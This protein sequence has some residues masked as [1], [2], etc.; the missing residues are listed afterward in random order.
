VQDVSQSKEGEEAAA[1]QAIRVAE[2]SPVA[3]VASKRERK[4]RVRE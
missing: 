2:R 1:M 3:G 4:E